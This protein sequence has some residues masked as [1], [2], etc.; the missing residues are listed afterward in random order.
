MDTD[1]LVR[2]QTLE[3]S[4]VES[5]RSNTAHLH[6]SISSYNEWR[7]VRK[8]ELKN[9]RREINAALQELAAQRRAQRRQTHESGTQKHDPYYHFV[10]LA[11][12]QMKPD[13]FQKAWEYALKKAR[14]AS[15]DKPDDTNK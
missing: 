3:R 4:I 10:E 8:A 6:G 2:L 1:D 9:V 7:S 11:R 5:L 13:Q 14:L 15:E 12:T